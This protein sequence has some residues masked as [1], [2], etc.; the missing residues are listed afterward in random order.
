MTRGLAESLNNVYLYCYLDYKTE[1]KVNIT[2]P[3]NRLQKHTINLL[4]IL[5]HTYSP[6]ASPPPR[7][8]AFP[9]SEI[10]SSEK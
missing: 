8:S 3:I 2:L 10:L 5:P 4:L 6:P 7:A 1:S 9:A